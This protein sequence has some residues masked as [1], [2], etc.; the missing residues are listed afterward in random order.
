[1]FLASSSKILARFATK[2]ATMTFFLPFFLDANSST[3]LV[4]SFL[5]NKDFWGDIITPFDLE[6]SGSSLRSESVSNEDEELDYSTI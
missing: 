2:G 4:L 6:D 5:F 3:S 1:M